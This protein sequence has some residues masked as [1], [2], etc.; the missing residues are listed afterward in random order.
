MCHQDV[1]R[2][3]Q[4]SY[5]PSG[6]TKKHL[7]IF[8]PQPS[9]LARSTLY[10]TVAFYFHKLTLS[11]LE[12]NIYVCKEHLTR[13]PCKE[14][15]ALASL[16]SPVLPSQQEGFSRALRRYLLL[17]KAEKSFKKEK[18]DRCGG[19]WGGGLAIQPRRSCA[20]HVSRVLIECTTEGLCLGA[21]ALGRWCMRFHLFFTV[22][23]IRL[24]QNL[25][26]LRFCG[27]IDGS[28]SWVFDPIEG[29]PVE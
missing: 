16:S 10:S 29:V 24:N 20:L 9:S 22:P 21:E 26:A 14:K 3:K 17:S 15:T 28:R 23:N 1:N 18:D 8:A 12:K 6:P 13:L 25:L 7:K 4:K 2:R 19:D 5:T 11:K 27:G